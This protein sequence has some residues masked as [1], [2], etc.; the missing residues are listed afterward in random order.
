MVRLLVERD[1]V[2]ADS[3]D[4]D[5]GT[6]LFWAAAGG[7]KAVFGVL[8]ERSDVAVDLKNE[9]SRTLRRNVSLRVTGHATN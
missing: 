2:E 9:K 1:D 6:P 7:H 4:K 8:V 5:G 3:K